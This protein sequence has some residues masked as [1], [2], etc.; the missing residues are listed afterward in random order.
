M[1]P[2]YTNGIICLI[3]TTWVPNSSTCM[4]NQCDHDS[5]SW[6][7]SGWGSATRQKYAFWVTLHHSYFHIKI[8]TALMFPSIVS[9]RTNVFLYNW[10]SLARSF[11]TNVSLNVSSSILSQTDFKSFNS[12]LRRKWKYINQ[13]FDDNVMVET[14]TVWSPF[15]SNLLLTI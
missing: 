15:W 11:D 12:Q 6:L 3:T 5:C 13:S 4:P 7:D 2:L 10:L 8:L 9:N 1:N 14:F